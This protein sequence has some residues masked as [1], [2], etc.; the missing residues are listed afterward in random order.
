MAVRLVVCVFLGVVPIHVIMVQKFTEFCLS[1]V[2]SHHFQMGSLR[3]LML[4]TP[5]RQNRL[6]MLN[7]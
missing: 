4:M 1:V 2:L 5:G 7:S 3:H 6:L